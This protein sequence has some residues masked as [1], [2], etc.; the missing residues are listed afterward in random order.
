MQSETQTMATLPMHKPFWSSLGCLTSFDFVT[1]I[2]LF[3][4]LQGLSPDYMNELFNFQSSDA[5]NLCY[6]SNYD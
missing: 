1:C 3:K 6:N 2:T 5:H 4:S